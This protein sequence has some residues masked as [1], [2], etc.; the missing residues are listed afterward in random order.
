MEGVHYS[1]I[2]LI[3]TLV[4]RIANYPDGFG[5][6]GKFVENST[7]LSFRANTG[8]RIKYSTVL[9]LL[10]I[11]I[12]RGRKVYAQVCTVNSN[13]RTTNFQFSLFK[14][15]TIIRISCLS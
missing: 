15:N 14:K 13:T 6:S 8:Y 9:W 11:Q 5:P 10:L 12:T 1:R 4:I 3:W 7:K 2:I